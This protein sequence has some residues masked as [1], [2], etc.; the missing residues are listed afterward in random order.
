MV[1]G[2]HAGGLPL[3]DGG[4]GLPVDHTVDAVVVLPHLDADLRLVVAIDTEGQP[5]HAVELRL[6]RPDAAGSQALPEPEER[7]LPKAERSLGPHHE[8]R[9]LHSVPAGT[10]RLSWSQRGDAGVAWVNWPREA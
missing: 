4:P 3:D 1:Q 6:P 9:H 5:H 8:G 2:Q 7:R 10:D